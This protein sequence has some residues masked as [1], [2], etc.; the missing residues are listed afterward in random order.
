MIAFARSL[1]DSLHSLSI[2]NQNLLQIKSIKSIQVSST[3]RSI[4]LV[5]A[6]RNS[7]SSL[8]VV[9]VL[10][11]TLSLISRF[12]PLTLAFSLLLPPPPP[13]ALIR[14]GPDR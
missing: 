10:L 1:C 14:D 13:L 3:K 11:F 9:L 6:Y 8:P 7:L 12:Q 4:S 5:F 2:Q